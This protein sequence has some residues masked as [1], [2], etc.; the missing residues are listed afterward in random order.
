MHIDHTAFPAK[1]NF[2][3]LPLEEF[4]RWYRHNEKNIDDTL[5]DTGALLL[6]GINIYSNDDFNFILSGLGIRP[7]DYHD[8]TTPRKKISSGI[9]SSTE[10]DSSQTINLHN[11]LSYSTKWPSRILFC[12]L[13]ASVS[14]GETP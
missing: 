2:S 8:G 12:C 7:L 11:E 1:V 4:I 3:N 9:Y 5:L 14:G 13:T 6:R 10:Y